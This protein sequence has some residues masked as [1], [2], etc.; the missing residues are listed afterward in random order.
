MAEAKS[1]DMSIELRLTVVRAILGGFSKPIVQRRVT[2]P[3]KE[4]SSR[5]ESPIAEA[6]RL[7]KYTQLRLIQAEIIPI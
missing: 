6:T 5:I 3:N 7:G 4:K 2:L 1:L